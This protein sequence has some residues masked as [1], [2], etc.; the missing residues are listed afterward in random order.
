LGRV[1]TCSL[2]TWWSNLMESHSMQRKKNDWYVA[3]NLIVDKWVFGDGCGDQ[4]LLWLQHMW[5]PYSD[6]RCE[7]VEHTLP[8]E[9]IHVLVSLLFECVARRDHRWGRSVFFAHLRVPRGTPSWTLGVH[10]HICT[11]EKGKS[12]MILLEYIWLISP[13][14]RVF[15]V[16]WDSSGPPISVSNPLVLTS[17]FYSVC[18]KVTYD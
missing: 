8:I 15:S 2:S 13:H 9:L 10:C 17:W 12:G 5:S 4:S 7:T 6:Q 11:T 14:S 16:H 3:D 18:Y 1:F